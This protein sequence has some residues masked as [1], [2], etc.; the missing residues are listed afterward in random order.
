MLEGG[1]A[2]DGEFAWND[3]EVRVIGHL[4]VL[5]MLSDALAPLCRSE[6]WLDLRTELRTLVMTLEGPALRFTPLRRAGE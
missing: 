2:E 1:L 4:S 3:R 5:L 6:Y